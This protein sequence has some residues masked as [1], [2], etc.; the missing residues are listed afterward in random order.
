M[1]L[2]KT[3]IK[4]QKFTQQFLFFIMK[5]KIDNLSYVCENIHNISK[6]STIKILTNNI[7]KKQIN[8]FKN[9]FKKK[10]MFKL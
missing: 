4:K 5:R 3:L 9:K 1:I 7:T 8:K 6:G 2:L 10:N